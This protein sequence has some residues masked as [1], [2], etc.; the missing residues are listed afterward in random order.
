MRRTL[1]IVWICAACAVSSPAASARAAAPVAADSTP[2]SASVDVS[3][4]A[5]IEQ[6]SRWVVALRVERTKDIA[7]SPLLPRR[8]SPEGKNLF[9]RPQACV[10][11]IL[12]SAEGNVLTSWYNVAGEVKS[13][14]VTLPTGEEYPAR[15]VARSEQDD[16]ALVRIESSGGAVPFSP[17]AWAEPRDS[18]GPRAGQ[19]VLVLGRSPEPGRV[20]VTRGILSAVA[21]NGGRAVQTDADIN[22]GNSGGIILNLDGRIVG[23]AGFVGH[24]QP[25]WGL[26]SGVGF[27]VSAH[28]IVEMLPRLQAGENVVAFQPGFLGVQCDRDGVSSDG[29]KVVMVV[30]DSA[31]ARAGL[32]PNDVILEV[33]GTAIF[34]F[35][36]LRRLIFPRKPGEVVRL[37]ARR[38]DETLELDATLGTISPP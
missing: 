17:P 19:I 9:Q 38:G 2:A 35:D 11:G 18:T 10:S 25:Q 28:T 5:L 16:A 6:A 8:I 26:N 4:D 22:Y 24:T 30:P 21:R 37:K 14:R 32:R 12:V 23:M 13:I 31:A 1:A 36:H 34:D 33:A 29:A 15:L 3:V 20:T 27:G 7:A